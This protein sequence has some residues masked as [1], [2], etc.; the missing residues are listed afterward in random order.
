MTSSTEDDGY[1]PAR[2]YAEFGHKEALFTA[3]LTVLAGPGAFQ[4]KARACRP[5]EKC[6]GL[7]EARGRRSVNRNVRPGAWRLKAKR[8]V[9]QRQRSGR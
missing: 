2:I 3:A 6:G 8:F 9:L 5:P 1:Q 4:R 7:P